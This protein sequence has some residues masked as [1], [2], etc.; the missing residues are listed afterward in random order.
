MFRD[1]C[2]KT[3]CDLELKILEDCSISFG[4]QRGFVEL[5]LMNQISFKLF[6]SNKS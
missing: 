2:V 3:I 5:Q 4:I 1:G 6:K